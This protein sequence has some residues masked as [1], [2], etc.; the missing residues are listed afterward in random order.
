M[1]QSL[2]RKIFGPKIAVLRVGFSADPLIY[3]SEAIINVFH[4]CT[5]SRNEKN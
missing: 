3:G 2:G 4:D 5:R 1:C